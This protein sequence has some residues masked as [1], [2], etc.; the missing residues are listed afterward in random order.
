MASGKC[1]ISETTHTQQYQRRSR[2]PS[3]SA[4][5]PPARVPTPP[6]M[7]EMS[8]SQVPTS[9]LD[10]PWMRMKKGGSQPPTP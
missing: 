6:M 5:Q 8:P 9:P 4:A 10:I 1:T 2:S 3:R 7:P